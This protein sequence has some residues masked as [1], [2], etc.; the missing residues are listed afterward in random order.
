MQRVFNQKRTF[1]SRNFI[2]D[3]QYLSIEQKSLKEEKS[4]KVRL[5]KVGNQKFYVKESKKP[6]IIATII[7]W[8][9]CILITIPF[10]FYSNHT[11]DDAIPFVFLEAIFGFGG[12]FFVLKKTK[13][14]IMIIGGEQNISFF[15]DK[16][17]EKEVEEFVDLVI[18]CANKYILEKYAKIDPDIPEDTQMNIFRWLRD[19]EL[20]KES[21]YEELKR[22]YKLK[23][24]I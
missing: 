3:N 14:E 1:S 15:N 2:L 5:D 22:E 20:L 10:I 18:N 6:G 23:K 13:N 19:R 16:K 4:W 9:I 8:T 11:K 12:L 21:E 24:M 17:Y 7:L